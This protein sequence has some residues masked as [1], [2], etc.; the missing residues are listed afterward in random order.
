MQVLYSAAHGGFSSEP[1]AL[2]GGAA[3]ANHLA[4]EW[5]RQKPFVF[6]ILSPELL[7][8]DAP[9]GQELVRY[10]ERTYARFC[11]AFEKKTT[12]TILGY[13]PDETVV[14]S[15]DVS[16]G[17]D[18]R[19]LAQKGYCLYTI[20]HVDVVDYVSKM[21]LRSWVRPSW[22]TS[23]Y[24]WIS[25]TP[26]ARIIPDVLALMVQKQR[27]SVFCSRGVIVPSQGMRDVLQE[28]YP[29]LE[30]SRIHVL[31]WGIWQDEAE[32]AA[33][34]PAAFRARY[35]IPAEAR[36]LLTLSRISPE[37]GQDRILRALALWEKEPDY[38]AAGV[39][40]FIAGEAAFMQGERFERRLK[41][42]ARRLRRTRVLFPGYASGPRKQ[43]LFRAA[44]LYVFPSRH[45]SYGL[46]LM[47]AMQAGLPVLS[48]DTAG[49]REV[50]T[51]G[52]GEILPALAERRIPQE[53]ARSLRRLCANRALLESCGEAA[54]R[55]AREH[56]FG[57]SA[58]KVAALLQ[59]S[60]SA[61]AIQYTNR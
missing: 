25:R 46:S 11:R 12:E 50:F 3:V 6:R 49:A 38:P 33:E 28:C 2:G 17:P 35:G 26:L 29:A 51:P 42:L 9:R 47:E 30:A 60:L 44:D 36:V 14:L 40:L 10:D 39:W 48:T 1:I 53:L 22:M 13:A 7:G 5:T 16:E 52:V 57:D 34:T 8:P 56:P 15:N 55:R 19:R 31:P 37:K 23:S 58:K 4:A 41:T 43:A 24:E 27:D 54:R 21:Y 18:F 61:R 32:G 20:F 45:E 59:S